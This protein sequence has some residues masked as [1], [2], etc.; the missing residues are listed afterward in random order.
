[1]YV[2]LFI[3]CAV[4]FFFLMIRRPP[5]STL[6]PYTTLF[7]SDRKSTRLNS[8]HDQI[9][10]A[11][12]CLKKKKKINTGHLSLMMM[13]L[14]TRSDARF[15]LLYMKLLIILCRVS[16]CVKRSICLIFGLSVFILLLI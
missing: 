10:Y 12:F 4:F 5:R 13:E 1:M 11:V 8:C 9:S 7:R 6:F 3:T 2:G 14:N 16:V 15:L